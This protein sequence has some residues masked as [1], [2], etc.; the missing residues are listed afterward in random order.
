MRPLA[1]LPVFLDVV[2]QRAV[3]AGGSARAAWKAELLLAA[4]AQVEVWA[5]TLEPEMAGLVNGKADHSIQ[6]QPRRWK[7]ETLAGAAV[8]F[9]DI[10]DEVE[11]TAFAAAAR[12]AGVP[13]NVI[14]KPALC[15]FQVGAIVNC[16]PIVIGISTNGAAPVLGQA[17]R[18]RIETLLP[19]WLSSWG[20]LA[21]AIRDTVTRKLP[22]ALQRRQFW[23]GFAGRAFAAPP[24][25][26]DKDPMRHMPA[27]APSAGR[28]TL[29]GAGPGD[30]ELLTVKA[31]RALHSADIILFD[32]LVSDD[33]LELARREARRLLVGK[34]GRRESCRQDD[35]NAL[36]V[37]LARQGKHVVRLKS[38]DPMIFG[39][40]GE[41]IAILEA[42]GI[43]VTVV[44]GI[45]A[46][47]AAAAALRTSL[48]HRDHAHSVRFITGHSRDGTLP[49]DLDWKG[50]ADPQTTLVFYMGGRTAPAI[51]ERL[52]S[53][54]LAATTPVVI[55]EGIGRAGEQR[56]GTTLDGLRTMAH[57]ADGGQPV[58]IGVGRAFTAAHCRAG[59]ATVDPSAVRCSFRNEAHGRERAQAL[60]ASGVG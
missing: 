1:K 46:A 36:M 53:S 18:Q 55:A 33:V 57:L 6:H 29:V 4:G 59:D 27:A 19:P 34:R 40:A 14:D 42:H 58:L 7:A 12:A 39:R 3:V 28:V 60:G 10:G 44:P 52:L 48:T 8:A 41:E 30:A 31:V 47:L 17:I 25:D 51:A 56:H 37:K 16:S 20:E 49:E 50:L 5:E 22:D 21:S 24:S 32:D 15:Q 45:T 9:A 2:G 23:E 38:G 54:G 26:G 43:E 13:V 35:I 11:A